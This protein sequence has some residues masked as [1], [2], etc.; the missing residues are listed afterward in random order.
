LANYDPANG[1]QAVV[2]DYEAPSNAA[3]LY[4][5]STG[6]VDYGLDP[7]GLQ[8]LS[9]PSPTASLTLPVTDF[10]LVDPYTQ[11][12]FFME[13]EGEVEF[14][15]TEPQVLYAPLGRSTEVVTYD[16]RK[17]KHFRFTLGMLAGAEFDAFE[18]LRLSGHVLFLQTPY[19]RSWYV[20]V[21]PAQTTKWLISPD[22]T[23]RFNVDVE[24]IEV[25]RPD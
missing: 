3:R 2:Y 10:W 5:V 6:G 19:A 14:V 18:A 8:T 9:A 12:R 11:A 20:K 15:S 17:S 25:A 22:V 4:R 16:V 24:L 1:W 7:L 13:Q 23:G 21:G